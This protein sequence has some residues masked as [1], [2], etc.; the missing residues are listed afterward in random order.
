VNIE[1]EH[2]ATG[3][4]N[5]G[6]P[7]YSPSEALT[8]LFP[9]TL[10]RVRANARAQLLAES[11]GRRLGERARVEIASDYVELEER[12]LRREVD[13]AWAPPSICARAEQAG[14]RIYKAMRHGRSMYRAAIV[15]RAREALTLEDLAGKRA[16][17]VD[18]LSNGGHL[19]AISLLR[20]HGL[21]PETLFAEQRFHESYQGALLSVLHGQADVSSIYTYGDTEKDVRRALSEHVGASEVQ[22]R[23]V[24]YTEESPSDGLI[25]AT[26]S[27]RMLSFLEA[28]D[29][30]QCKELLLELMDAD[31]LERAEFNDYWAVRQALVQL[32]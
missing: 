6:G 7:A 32:S 8:I 13:I 27:D 10:G 29:R 25:C 15:C 30:D 22:L 4:A 12:V 19:L 17:W 9:P 16:A 18:P 23:T 3:A 11:L 2:D 21:A 31:S 20:Q 14:I 5:F 1:I 24:A 26:E 28:D